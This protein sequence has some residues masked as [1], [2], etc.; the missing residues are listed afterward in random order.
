MHQ[1]ANALQPTIAA[2]QGP[3]HVRIAF[4]T[5]YRMTTTRICTCHTLRA[6]VISNMHSMVQDVGHDPRDGNS[7]ATCWN[8]WIRK[9]ITSW[10]RCVSTYASQGQRLDSFPASHGWQRHLTYAVCQVLF[11][12][13]EKAA[14]EGS[15][16]NVSFSIW[17][18][19]RFKRPQEIGIDMM[20][21]TQASI[22]STIVAV[23]LLIYT[24]LQG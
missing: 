12:C 14:R 6:S 3:I 11:W 9:E 17:N 7:T 4:S 21:K 1:L 16:C 22:A 18:Y 13:I 19:W 23:A 2:A 15:C 8:R 20:L 5:Y 24:L 10:R